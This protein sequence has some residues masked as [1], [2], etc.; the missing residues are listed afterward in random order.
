LFL[1]GTDP[2][3][4]PVEKKLLPIGGFERFSRFRIEAERKGGDSSRAQVTKF[5]LMQSLTVKG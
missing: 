3:V 2:D 5:A 4:T 1:A